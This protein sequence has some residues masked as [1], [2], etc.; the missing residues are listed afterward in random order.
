VHIDGT[1]EEQLL[2][3]TTLS[4]ISRAFTFYYPPSCLGINSLWLFIPTR[5]TLVGARRVDYLSRGAH[6]HAFDRILPGLELARARSPP[7]EPIGPVHPYRA[8]T[9]PIE[10]INPTGPRPH[11]TQGLFVWAFWQLLDHGTWKPKQTDSF[12]YEFQNIEKP[13]E[14]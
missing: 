13:I 12:Q 4:L 7:I 1:P 6:G 9:P 10:P 14:A 3:F 11:A 8:N 2:S 5:I